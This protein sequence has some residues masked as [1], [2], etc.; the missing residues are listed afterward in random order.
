[1]HITKKLALLVLMSTVCL[2]VASAQQFTIKRKKM[3]VTIE[4]NKNCPLGI[5][6]SGR[7]V[8]G[9][10]LC[11]DYPEGVLHPLEKLI[12]SAAEVEAF[13]TFEG[14]PKR[15]TPVALGK[16]IRVDGDKVDDAVAAFQNDVQPV[17]NAHRQLLLLRGRDESTRHGGTH[18]IRHR[19]DRL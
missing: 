4:K 15:E 13:W 10:H 8:E 6:V 17:L 1:M 19:R 14:N 7:F 16:V 11:A 5:S 3:T 2:G 9:R 12:G 18:P